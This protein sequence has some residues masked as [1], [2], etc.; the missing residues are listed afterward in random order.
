MPIVHYR[1][2]F[3]S[4]SE[5]INPIVQTGINTGTINHDFFST[6]GNGYVMA[7]EVVPIK[8]TDFVFAGRL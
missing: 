8:N 7:L 5:D 2:W 4:F 1:T 3:E 6:K